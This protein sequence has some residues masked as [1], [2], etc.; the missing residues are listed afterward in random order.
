MR[1][2]AGHVLRQRGYFGGG[3]IDMVINGAKEDSWHAL[4]LN[5]LHDALEDG[6]P[7]FHSILALEPAL[8]VHRK[9]YCDMTSIP[10]HTCR[11]AKDLY[12]SMSRISHGNGTALCRI[13]KD[14]ASHYGDAGSQGPT[15][16]FNIQS[17]T[18]EC[19]GKSS[20]EQL[21]IVNGIQLR[22]GGVC[23]PGGIAWA[24]DLTAQ[25]MRENYAEG[26]RCGN[27]V[28]ELNGKP[29]GIVRVSLGAMGNTDDVV[30]LLSFLRLFIEENAGHVGVPRALAEKKSVKESMTTWVEET[31][32]TECTIMST[33]MTLNE[34]PTKKPGDLEQQYTE[35]AC[36]VPGCGAI[37][38]TE[39]KLLERFQ[40]HKTDRLCKAPAQDS[41]SS[42]PGAKPYAIVKVFMRKLRHATC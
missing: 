17:S 40:V 39:E 31:L 11:L 25:E 41:Q 32:T 15:I 42:K 7:A 29:T 20:V 10:R 24:L 33:T 23:N 37:T 13:Y 1:K 26:L 3:T 14:P 12:E 16:A 38:L 35:Y 27:G 36:P 2:D 18:Q 34:K 30:N 4:K 19:V 5:F 6:T 22:T 8:E 9:L 28:D 21:A